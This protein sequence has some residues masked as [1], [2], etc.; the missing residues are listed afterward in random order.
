MFA[1][2]SEERIRDALPLLRGAATAI[3]LSIAALVL[4]TVIG[5]GVLPNPG[6]YVELLRQYSSRGFGT[7]PIPGWSL[8]YAICASYIISFVALGV[9]VVHG[10]GSGA[11]PTVDDRS[12]CRDDS[13]WCP[14]VHLLLGRSHPNNLTHISPP[15]VVMV[16]LWVMLA[17]RSCVYRRQG[18]A[19][20]AVIVAVAVSSFVTVVQWTHFRAKAADSALAGIVSP[21]GPSLEQDLRTM[22]S[23]PT[24]SEDSELVEG[25]VRDEVPPEVPLLVLVEPTVATEVLIRL[26]RSNVLP[27]S[28]A[29]QDGLVTSRRDAIIADAADVPCDTMVVTQTSPFWPGY[30][31]GAALTEGVLAELHANFT[32][33]PVASI[34]GYNI[35]RL[36]CPS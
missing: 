32:F 7:L 20:A 15:F 3:V 26:D 36:Q 35:D 23:N 14:V 30:D 2:A 9:I 16:A 31:F 34:L 6:Q 19:P 25:F 28:H 17:L 21:I 22:T 24:I 12:N 27:I 29:T 5:R 4:A 10:R 33:A 8:G 13:V 18:L 11:G 1:A